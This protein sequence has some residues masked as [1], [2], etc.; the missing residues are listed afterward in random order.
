MYFPG[1]AKRDELRKEN[2]YQCDIKLVPEL[3]KFPVIGDLLF[4]FLPF[5]LPVDV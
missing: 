1:F 5:L 4:L 3:L 2:D